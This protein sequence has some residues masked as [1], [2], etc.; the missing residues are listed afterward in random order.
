M[1]VLGSMWN[2]E[3][4]VDLLKQKL[5]CTTME[6]E[7]LKVEA[8]EEMRKH[9]EDMTELINL[10]KL[11]YQ[12]RDEA[13]DQLQKLVNKL[14]PSSPTDLGPLVPHGQPESPFVMTTK[15]NSSITESSSL[16]DTH[17]HQSHGSSP[18]DSFFDTVSSP[19]FSSINMADSSQLGFANNTSVRQYTGAMSTGVIGP[20]AV[21]I[22]PTDAL[23]D[24]LV[25]GKALP[26]K[27][28]LLEAVM[29]S[30]PLLQTLLLA[31][32]L[33]RWRNPP[34]LQPFKIEPVLIKDC[35]AAHQKPAAIASIIPH[36]QISQSCV[37][38]S[39]VSSQTCSASM[40]NFSSGAAGNGW[41]LNCG[42]INQIAAGKRQRL[43]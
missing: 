29:E 41:I 12:E 17:N 42:V 26:Q 4:S 6:L 15:A 27:G 9:K 19:D 13:K 8:D 18:V 36:K 22:D 10:L 20:A 2:Y 38:M 32:P 25:K 40:L 31:G 35:E 1:E 24:N 43:Q 3:E 14:M 5:M 7:S 23:M 11:A 39:R 37:E 16:S 33:P 21:K 30:A 28:K 34:P